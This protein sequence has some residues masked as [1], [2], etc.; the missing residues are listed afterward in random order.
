MSSGFIGRSY[1]DFRYSSAVIDADPNHAGNILLLYNRASVSAA[2]D[3]GVTWNREH[4]WLVETAVEKCGG[5]RS[6][7]AAPGGSKLVWG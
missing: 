1:G 2:W 7:S 4:Q 5:W 6:N 3:G